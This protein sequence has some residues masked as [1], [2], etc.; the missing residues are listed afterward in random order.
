MGDVTG[1]GAG[2]RCRHTDHQAFPPGRQYNGADRAR[3]RVGRRR[4]RPLGGN[5]GQCLAT[6]SLGTGHGEAV[7]A[8]EA[9]LGDLELETPAADYSRPAEA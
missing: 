6:L 7:G 1:P 4:V 9:P 8:K 2:P 5:E 3:H